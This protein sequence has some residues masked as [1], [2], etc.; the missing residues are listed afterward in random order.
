MFESA[1]IVTP[2][3]R[4]PVA[5]GIDMGVK[6]GDKSRYRRQRSSRGE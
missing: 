1:D 6:T 4:T 3:G 2:G 5:K